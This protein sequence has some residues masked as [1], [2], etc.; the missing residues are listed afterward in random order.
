[1]F[2][3]VIKLNKQG[4]VYTKLQSEQSFLYPWVFLLFGN[5]IYYEIPITYK[6]KDTPI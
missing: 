2:N 5:K 4:F 1:M 6:F 3:D